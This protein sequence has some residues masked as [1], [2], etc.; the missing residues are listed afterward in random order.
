MKQ[1]S[2]FALTRKEG[3]AKSGGYLVVST[4]QTDDTA[5]PAQKYGI[6]ATKKIGNAVVRNKLRRRIQAIYA[7]HADRLDH[8]EQNRYIVTILRWRA[9][10]ATFAQLENDW[11]KQVNR[12]G[13]LTSK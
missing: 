2:E 4:V 12:L 6:I 3:Q 13:I 9:P 1:H 7:K 5:A 11:L 8:P 10:Q